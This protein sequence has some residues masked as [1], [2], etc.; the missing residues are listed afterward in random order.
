MNHKNNQITG[1]NMV[2]W[3]Y[4]NILLINIVQNWEHPLVTGH[5]VRLPVHHPFQTA[6]VRF[7]VQSAGKT[8]SQDEP[9]SFGV[10][11]LLQVFVPICG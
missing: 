4:S 10:C 2:N 5:S 3:Y 6:C 8:R 1:L 7:F 11:A 9:T